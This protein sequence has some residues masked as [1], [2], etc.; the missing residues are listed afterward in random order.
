MKKSKKLVSL[1]LALA[2]AP[3][4]MAM[5]ALAAATED[6]QP[7][8]R[9][10]PDC[11]DGRLFDETYTYDNNDQAPCPKGGTHTEI[12]MR[13]Y[14]YCDSCTFCIGPSEYTVVVCSKCQ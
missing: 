11:E 5:P 9:A 3:S 14:T 1:F 2:F 12:Y 6:I 13:R 8:Y 10:C 4:L 7:R